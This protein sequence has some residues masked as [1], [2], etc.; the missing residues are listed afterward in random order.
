MTWPR[1][2]HGAPHPSP[3]L[4]PSFASSGR[5][6]GDGLRAYFES[7]LGGDLRDV[8]VHTDAS[9]AQAA[10]RL[11]ARA[12]TTGRD[13][14]FAAG[15]YAPATATGRALLT[16]ELQDD[17]Q[18]AGEAA[19]VH[20][21]ISSQPPLRSRDPRSLDDDVLTVEY[22]RV[23]SANDPALADYLVALEAE[24]VLRVQ[25]RLYVMRRYR[26]QRGQEPQVA[27]AA[28]PGPLAI[29]LALRLL[30]GPGANAGATLTSATVQATAW[31]SSM[32]SSASRAASRAPAG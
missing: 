2:R 23:L 26:Q 24:L 28:V 1:R 6:L 17:R 9:A 8:R 10:T 13:I 16:H 30:L 14:G 15:E 21:Q 5:E 11:G 29:A 22:Q 19:I 31:S 32:P 3:R 12:F 7:S 4:R 18:A 20:R 27:Q 25:S